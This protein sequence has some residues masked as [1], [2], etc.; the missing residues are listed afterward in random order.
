MSLNTSTFAIYGP[1]LHPVVYGFMFIRGLFR[2]LI[3]S[4]ISRISEYWSTLGAL[5]A[6][7]LSIGRY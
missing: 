7:L 3:K 4:L 1:W 5:I 6:L 2:L